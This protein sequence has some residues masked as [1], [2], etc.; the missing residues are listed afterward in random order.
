MLFAARH[1]QSI[2]LQDIDVSKI[3]AYNELVG[4]DDGLPPVAQRC[5]SVL[6][7]ETSDE[8]PPIFAKEGP[9]KTLYG[10]RQWLLRHS[11]TNRYRVAFGEKAVTAA[12]AEP[13]DKILCARQRRL[14]REKK[15][16]AEEETGLVAGPNGFQLGPQAE[17][18]LQKSHYER[19][20]DEKR[21]LYRKVKHLKALSKMSSFVIEELCAVFDLLRIEEA[22][23]VLFKQGE[24]GTTFYVLLK[25]SVSVMI[26]KTGKFADSREV[27]VLPAG[28]GF[29]EVA[30]LSGERRSSSIVLREPCDFLVVEKVDYLRIMKFLHDKDVQEK[31]EFL[32]RIPIFSSWTNDQLRNVCKFIS[33]RT[34]KEKDI[35]INEG[36]QAAEMFF[37]ANGMVRV[38]RRLRVLKKA[39]RPST[40]SG[41]LHI[42]KTVQVVMGTLS[43]CEHF[44]HCGIL[45][46]STH[47]MTVEAMDETKVAVINAFNT[48]HFLSRVLAISPHSLK[49]DKEIRRIYQQHQQSAEWRKFKDA[50]VTQIFVEKTVRRSGLS[51]Y[52]FIEFRDS[53]LNTPE[54]KPSWH[55]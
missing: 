41:A 49:S 29:G 21:L 7:G 38:S 34:F 47:T 26:S 48:E 14:A 30:L 45:M 35:I 3:R 44:G 17:T 40:V 18:V 6:K 43:M 25:G 4:V 8:K 46:R 32:R 24:L 23:H 51:P 52:G 13:V 54:G 31:Q 15:K 28:A 11:P 50:V 39:R 22:G 10:E 1:R 12:P 2:A 53:A 55:V 16:A 27:V 36:D 42:G 19:T 5:V 20:N 33:W 37:I 9:S